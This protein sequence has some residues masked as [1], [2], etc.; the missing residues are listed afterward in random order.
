[1]V[2]IVTGVTSRTKLI[3]V[4]TDHAYEQLLNALDIEKQLTI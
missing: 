3:R 4:A 2:T 1:M